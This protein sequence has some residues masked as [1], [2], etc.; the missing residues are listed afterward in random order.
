MAG[1]EESK[2]KPS[3]TFEDTTSLLR[4]VYADLTRLSQIA[5]PDIILHTADR[6]LYSPAKEPIR[7]VEAAQTYEEQLVAATGGTIV[8][9]VQSFSANEH[10]GTV[11]GTLQA[12]G[13]TGRTVS[14]AFC[15][16]WRF[17]DGKAVEHWENAF[18]PV[19][20]RDWFASNEC[21]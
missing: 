4:Y 9:E 5:S 7:G 14:M 11:L 13:S 12:A 1:E 8:M 18:D 3:P 21:S 19:K 16:V 2:F 20:F 6:S 10:F 17:V 15:G